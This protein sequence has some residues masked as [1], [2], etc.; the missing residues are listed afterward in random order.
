[1]ADLVFVLDSSGSIGLNNWYKITNFTANVVNAF[2]IAQENVRVGVLWYGNEA[3][4][5][6]YLNTYTD[7]RQIL[8][9][10]RQIPW[11]DQE[12]NTSGAIRTMRTQMFTPERGDRPDV[13]NIGVVIT[14]G[15][16][17]RDADLTIPEAND[18]KADGII[19]F[20][21][22]IGDKVSM[23][24]LIGI[25]N[26]PK[27]KYVFKATDF[28]AL[29]NIE[30]QVESA[31]CEA[32]AGRGNILEKLPKLL[33]LKDKRLS[34]NVTRKLRSIANSDKRKILFLLSS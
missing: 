33:Y 30:V 28:D 5:A 6:F 27:D 17:N 18:A 31:A 20:A 24:E 34:T 32:A 14:D 9:E 21:L 19:M 25:A 4:V 3:D 13:P 11:K 29:K 1:M 22:G 12:T 23:D 8:D 15:E 2:N 16:S 10:I 26:S 7:R